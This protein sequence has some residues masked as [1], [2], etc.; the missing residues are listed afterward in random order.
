MTVKVPSEAV[1]LDSNFA[2]I[3]TLS[4]MTYAAL[5][6][7]EAIATWALLLPKAP[8]CK[9][10]AQLHLDIHAGNSV[11]W[12]ICLISK[13]RSTYRSFPGLL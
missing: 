2:L 8:G 7:M 13:T 6:S 3:N 11:G 10:N 4:S 5:N 1:L 9:R 12:Q